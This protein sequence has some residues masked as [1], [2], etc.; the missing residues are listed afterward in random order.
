MRPP[1]SITVSAEALSSSSAELSI[2]SGK[3]HG[4][5]VAPLENRPCRN[6]HS[7]CRSNTR[8]ID[9]CSNRL[10][11]FILHEE[12]TT[13]ADSVASRDSVSP[14]AKS[15]AYSLGPASLP[16]VVPSEVAVKGL[17]VPASDT[18]PIARLPK[19]IALHDTGRT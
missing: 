11:T 14:Y 13:R 5:A 17:K 7:W 3:A 16:R 8:I 2:S 1:G 6:E 4:G 9:S 19:F 10:R 12:S 15:L 18:P